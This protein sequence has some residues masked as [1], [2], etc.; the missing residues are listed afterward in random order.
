MTEHPKGSTRSDAP[1]DPARSPDDAC[2]A[3]PPMPHRFEYE[4]PPECAGRTLAV[5]CWVSSLNL[6]RVTLEYPALDG[7][8]TVGVWEGEGAGR[9][10][11]DLTE[12]PGILQLGASHTVV[13]SFHSRGGADW[14]PVHAVRT[15]VVLPS[16]PGRR[17]LRF[18]AE[19]S[20]SIDYDWDDAILRIWWSV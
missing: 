17:E 20:S 18:C 15:T 9:H 2:W 8:P 4:L 16:G 6:Q 12:G 1:P 3:G 13:V 7:D 19:D 10:A 5:D 14:I 11:M